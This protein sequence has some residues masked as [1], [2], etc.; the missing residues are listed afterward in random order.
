MN[1]F[2][3]FLGAGSN[4]I[5]RIVVLTYSAW[6]LEIFTVTY[7]VYFYVAVGRLQSHF[8]CYG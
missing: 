6:L 5:M 7:V 2:N 3:L 4:I 1:L 8:G